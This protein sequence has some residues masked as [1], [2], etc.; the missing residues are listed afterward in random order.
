[1]TEAIVTVGGLTMD[2]TYRQ[3]EGVLQVG[4]QFFSDWY[5]LPESK[6][7][8]EERPSAEGAFDVDQDLWSSLP[9]QLDGSYRGDGWLTTLNALSEQVSSGI[10]LVVS[11]T[12]DLGTTSRMVRVRRFTPRPNPGARVLEFTLLM[13]A[14][15]PRRYGPEVSATTG[16]PTSGT[17]YVWP[18]AWPADWGSGGDPG[19]ATVENVGRAQSWPV[20]EVTGG[21]SEGVE[22]VEIATGSIL[23]LDRVIPLGSTVVF[24][25]RRGRAYLDVPS[26]DVTGFL[27]RR[28]WWPVPAS[29]S[30]TVQFNALGAVTGTPT[31]TVRVSPAY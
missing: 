24:D 30:R 4:P 11:V 18:A 25:A 5:S 3:A 9:L 22:L 7:P 29:Q 8:V 10:P 15:D 16:L 12:D 14:T 17:G 2:G 27:T 26:N 28:E 6:V 13:L 20:L 21:L 19:R 23:R 1:M 31:L